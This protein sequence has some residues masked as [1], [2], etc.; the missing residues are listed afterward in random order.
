MLLPLLPKPKALIPEFRHHSSLT[1]ADSGLLLLSLVAR[2]ERHMSTFKM[3]AVAKL[4]Q[5]FVPFA[6]GFGFRVKCKGLGFRF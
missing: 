2:G 1:S 3:D 4:D 5:P 6:P